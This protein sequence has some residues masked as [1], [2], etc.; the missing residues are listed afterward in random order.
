MSNH[1]LIVDMRSTISQN[2]SLRPNTRDL[3]LWNGQRNVS[4][5]TV[6]HTLNHI[7]RQMVGWYSILW[8]KFHVPRFSFLT[9]VAIHKR[10][11]TVDRLN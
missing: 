8:N 11:S 7:A 10:L 9:W 2:I 5:S 4:L 3:I 1:A 6:W